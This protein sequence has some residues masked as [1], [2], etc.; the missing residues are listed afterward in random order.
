MLLWIGRRS[1]DKP[2]KVTTERSGLDDKKIRDLR[3]KGY[4]TDQIL[5]ISRAQSDQLGTSNS[6]GKSPSQSGVSSAQAIHLANNP[7][8]DKILGGN[9]FEKF[10]GGSVDALSKGATSF[11]NLGTKVSNAAQ[12]T[13]SKVYG[14]YAQNVAVGVANITNNI[15]GISGALNQS[16]DKFSK[17]IEIN[18]TPV[19]EF[20]GSSLATLTGVI[21]DPLGPKGL[22]NVATKLLNSVS[23]GMGDK[24]NGL[25]QSLQLEVLGRLPGQIM[26][27]LERIY[28]GVKD[29]LLIPL[30][31][32]ADIYSQLLSIMKSLSNLVNSVID[33][34]FKLLL[35]FLDSIIPIQSILSLLDS[36]STLAGQIGGIAGAF[37]I[38]AVTNI[39]GQLGNFTSAF[40]NVLSNPVDFAASFLPPQVTDVLSKIQDPQSLI[41][42][43]LPGEIGGF[44]SGLQNP[45]RLLDQFLPPDLL[46]GLAKISNMAGLNFTGNLGFGSKCALEQVQGFALA[47][48]FQNFKTH[49]GVVGPILAGR[50]NAPIGYIPE[51]KEGHSVSH[52][53]EKRRINKNQY[54]PSTSGGGKGESAYGYTEEDGLLNG[55]GI[56]ETRNSDGSITRTVNGVTETT[57]RPRFSDIEAS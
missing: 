3:T 38:S 35:N 22:G 13:Y 16:L 46:S 28:Q 39:T 53:N 49:A 32:L 54:T 42:G 20:V 51:L 40:S 25:N 19:S 43:M 10:F 17:Q 48:V 14:N 27:G 29:L 50:P 56:S 24:I 34:F 31:I 41:E 26:S 21:D 23:P 36:V 18:L 7:N 44:L 2:M 55:P 57:P 30:K 4:T 15:D 45:E 47:D 37:G 52:Y 8:S 5:A 6:T 9:K 1:Q 33:G 12:I 11:E